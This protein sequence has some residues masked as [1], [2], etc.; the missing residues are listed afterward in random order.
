MNATMKLGSR[1]NVA[2]VLHIVRK[3]IVHPSLEFVIIITYCVVLEINNL[4]AR[5]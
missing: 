3:E 4:F 1:E 5:Y 2:S